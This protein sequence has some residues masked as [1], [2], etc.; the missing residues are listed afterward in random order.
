MPSES[1]VENPV[2]HPALFAYQVG[3]YLVDK[4]LSPS[5]P[6]PSK[7][8]RRPHVAVIGAGITGVSSAAQ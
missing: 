7:P 8:L 4:A 6:D 2:T 5:P 1:K 3:Q